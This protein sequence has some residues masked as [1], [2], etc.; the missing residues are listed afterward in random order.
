[1]KKKLWTSL[2]CL[3]LA[4]PVLA[5]NNQHRLAD[6]TTVLKTA[7]TAKGGIPQS[8][9]DS[10]VCVVVYPHVKKIGAGVGVTYGRGVLTCRSGLQKTGEWGSPAMYSLNAG[11]VGPQIGGYSVDYVLLITNETAADKILSGKLKL[12]AD[13]NAVAGPS[14]ATTEGFNDEKLGASILIYSRGEDGLFAGASLGDASMEADDK[15]NHKLYGRSI[16]ANEIVRD[17]K[18]T[19]PKA[20]ES[21]LAELK[22]SQSAKSE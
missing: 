3:A 1:M 20:A 12:G 19:V 14:K 8:A 6:A 7:L 11:S 4:I 15:A 10:A 2:L 18:V 21:F 16:D 9:L 22:R 13:A 5:E 17:G